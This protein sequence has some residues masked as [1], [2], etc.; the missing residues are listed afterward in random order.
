MFKLILA[1]SSLGRKRLLDYLQLN[2]EIIP[3]H[4]DE[5]KIVGKTPI[6]TIK[7]RARLKGEAIARAAIAKG[8]TA[9][10][11]ILS[12]DSDAIFKNQVI[13]KAA[14]RQQAIKNLSILSGNTH[15][16]IT[17]VHIIKIDINKSKTQQVIYSGESKS[18]VT[19][20]KIERREIEYYLDHT[21]FTRFAGSYALISAQYFITKVEGSISNVVG[22]P[23]ETVI[24]V[25]IKESILKQSL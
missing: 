17:S 13:G 25:L 21:D 4:L 9:T 18:K 19:F 6:E 16:F 22:L 7:L 11:I 2:Y 15:L 20:R 3:S 14:N 8:F 12:A 24:P 1:S 23:L 5:D 10:Q